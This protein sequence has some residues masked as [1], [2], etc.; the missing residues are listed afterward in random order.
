[1]NLRALTF[2]KATFPIYVGFFLLLFIAELVFL[3]TCPPYK[4]L[5]IISL[6]YTEITLEDRLFAF[7]NTFTINR[8]PFGSHP[9]EF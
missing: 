7:E 3:K 2:F 1:M 4:F 5:K 6:Q 9:R 8:N